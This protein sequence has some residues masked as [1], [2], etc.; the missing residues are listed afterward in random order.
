M[1]PLLALDVHY[2]DDLNMACAAGLWFADWPS[3]S[4][5]G[6]EIRFVE[7][8]QPYEPGSFYKRELPCLLP[9]VR[10]L[11]EQ[12]QPRA[13]IVDAH[14]DLGPGR[15]G[16]GRHLYDAIE[17]QTEIVGV[18][19]RPFHGGVGIEVLRGQSGQAL[20]VTSTHDP[21]VAA[22]GITAM[23][24]PHRLPTLLKAVDRLARDGVS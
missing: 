4:P 9:L 22:R 2:V 7:G 14:V 3:A 1:N 20:W 23:A 10:S 17:Q 21:V 12:L 11:L 24:G 13:L 15:P 19:K 6:Q 16:L 5:A 18:A 8:L